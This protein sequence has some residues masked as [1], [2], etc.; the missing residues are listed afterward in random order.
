MNQK[1]D[2]DS[3]QE[4]LW[5]R[6]VWGLALFIISF[7]AGFSLWKGLNSL[8]H[9]SGVFLFFWPWSDEELLTGAVSF[10][11]LNVISRR[12]TYEAFRLFLFERYRQTF[13]LV[14]IIASILS[15]EFE[16]PF[17]FAGIYGLGICL[18]SLLILSCAR[19]IRLDERT[20]IVRRYCDLLFPLGAYLATF[21][22][23]WGISPFHSAENIANMWFRLLS[24]NGLLWLVLFCLG[25]AYIL[26]RPNAEAH[27]TDA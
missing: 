27:P 19:T 25:K 9:A 14:C 23:F 5:L 10:F 15:W 3:T 22:T 1:Q 16:R 12:Y 18:W 6:I 20:F 26:L 24:L 8:V 7:A 11:G 21:Y 4:P 17:F 2:A 13:L